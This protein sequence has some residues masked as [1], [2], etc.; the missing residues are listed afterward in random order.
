MKI[1]MKS[2]RKIYKTIGNILKSSK[3]GRGISLKFENGIGEISFFTPNLFRVRITPKSEFDIDYSYA[4]IKPIEDWESFEVIVKDEPEKITIETGGLVLVLTKSPYSMDVFTIDP[5]TVMRVLCK[6]PEDGFGVCVNLKEGK[7]NIRCF[8][9]IRQLEHFFGFGEKTGPLDKAGESMVMLANDMP[10]SKNADP[11]YQDHPFFISI[12]AGFSYGIFFDNISKTTFD[13]GKTDPEEYYFDAEHGEL[14]YYFISER[15]IK[16]IL[17]VYTE[18]TGRMKMPP[19][20]SIGYHQCKYSYKNEKQIKKITNKFRLNH[21]PCDGIWFD[22]HYMTGYR[23]FTFN[24]KRFPSP[25]GL[26]ESLKSLGFKATAIVDP[27]VKID[28]YY[29]VYQEIIENKFYC[30]N[31]EG[32]PAVGI[33]WPGLVHFPDFTK[34]EVRSWWGGLHK[35]YFDLGLDGIWIDMNEPSLNINPL[36]SFI[37]RVKPKDIF[38]DDQGRNSWLNKA[39]NVYGFGQA[40][41]TYEGFRKLRPNKRPFILT[42]SGYAGLQRYAA[43]W[44]GDNWTT[45]GGIALASRMLTNLCLSAQSFCGEDIGGHMGIIRMVFKRKQLFAR[46]L[47][48]GVFHPFCRVHTTVFTRNQDPF[49]NGKKVQAICKKYIELRYKLLPYL[50]NLFY[51]YS[52]TGAPIMRPLFYYTLGDENCYRKDFENQ[53]LFGSDILIVPIYKKNCKHIKTYL[54]EGKWIHLWTGVEFEGNREYDIDVVL[55]DIPILIRKG[56][57]IPM[58][59][60]MEYVG[61]KPVDPLILSIYPDLDTKDYS[62]SAKIYS[63]D[64]ESFDYEEKNEW[65]KLPVSVKNNRGVLEIIIKKLEGKYRPDFTKLQFEIVKISKP[66]EVTVDGQKINQLEYETE[67]ISLLRFTIPF[68]NEETKLAISF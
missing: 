56:A 49:S 8:K 25:K 42:R 4:V 37:H 1:Q 54:P 23:V 21:I 51:E 44:T 68:K 3:I 38:F 19:K 9:K 48:S 43:M 50:Y 32:D 12:S 47:Q 58:Q 61:E 30:K 29:P 40:Q 2:E 7:E 17:E 28:E 45:W 26:I 15:S 60:D 13:M 46:W 6:E 41:A 36:K 11:L 66:E 22:I 24:K 62:N 20:W 39:R 35:F 18:L 57:I 65:C 63:D 27:G 34:P 52:Q 10:Y 53:F 14:N 64:G 33:V 55:E 31:A 67:P 5:N 59:P 16:G